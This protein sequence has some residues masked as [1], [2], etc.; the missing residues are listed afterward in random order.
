MCETVHEKLMI[1]VGFNSQITLHG[2]LVNPEHSCMYCQFSNACMGVGD[3]NECQIKDKHLPSY[4]S[5]ILAQTFV[6]TLL[7]C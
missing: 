7:P 5:N 1:C 2:L 3:T 4:V 6:E